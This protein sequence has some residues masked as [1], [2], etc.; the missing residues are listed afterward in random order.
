MVCGADVEIDV[1][2]IFEGEVILGNN[3]KIGAYTHLKDSNI[4]DN[5]NI[6]PYSHIDTSQVGMNNNIGPYARLRPGAKTKNNVNIGNFV[7]I[8]N[9]TVGAGTKINHLSYVGDSEVG[10]NVNIGAGCITCNYDGV[11]KH[12][13][14]LLYTSDAADE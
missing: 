9:S 13:T 4:L 3:V 7:E 5:S 1:G 12:K 11:N 10:E 8:K 6:K 2:C 14:C